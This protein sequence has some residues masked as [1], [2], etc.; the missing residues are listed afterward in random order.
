MSNLLEFDL[1]V[2]VFCAIVIIMALIITFINVYFFIWKKNNKKSS[3]QRCAWKVNKHYKELYDILS[4]S[5]AW[6]NDKGGDKNEDARQNLIKTLATCKKMLP[7]R[8]TDSEGAAYFGYIHFL[9]SVRAA[10]NGCLYMRA[11]HELLN[12]VYLY[13]FSESRILNSVVVLLSEYLEDCTYEPQIKSGR[14]KPMDVPSLMRFSCEDVLDQLWKHVVDETD[15]SKK[16]AMVDYFTNVIRMDVRSNPV[17]LMRFVDLDKLY[18]SEIF[19]LRYHDE[20]DKTCEL[21]S[22]GQEVFIDTSK[23]AVMILPPDGEIIMDNLAIALKCDYKSI[24][25][26]TR[27]FYSSELGM[28]FV[29]DRKSRSLPDIARA[30]GKIAAIC[31][32]VKPLFANIRADDWG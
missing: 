26:D 10:L 17:P 11:C 6:F 5:A 19:P 22:L 28:A 13:P 31:V 15:V 1:F 21:K 29:L 2:Q 24:E 8:E 25:A 12:I 7:G 4:S 14:T 30:K 20:N 27:A 16:L 3:K 32:D 18:N 9:L 23:D